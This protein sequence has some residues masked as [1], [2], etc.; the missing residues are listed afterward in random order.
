MIVDRMQCMI[1]LIVLFSMRVTFVLCVLAVGL[2]ASSSLA[3]S[4][5]VARVGLAQKRLANIHIKARGIGALF[6]RLS[7]SYDIPIGLEIA[8]NDDPRAI[9]QLD[10]QNGTLAELLTQFAAEQNQYA[11]EIK[12]G[13]VNVFPKNEYRD[14]LLTE[15]LNTEISSFA[16][17]KRTSCWALSDALA[18][19]PEIKSILDA[20]RMTHSPGYV[21]GFYIPQLGKK[22]ALTVS[23]MNLKSILDK[24]VKESPV[25][26]IWI[27]SRNSSEEML[28]TVSARAEN[29]PKNWPKGDPIEFGTEKLP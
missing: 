4:S 11:R 5:M 10:L 9:Y 23:Q 13:V 20:N 27:V 8:G 22:F 3:Q 15:L 19:T 24:V 21:A 29:L 1:K 18:A 17:K 6:S 14:A 2:G 7:L 12:N 25:A 28:L 26:R 16:V